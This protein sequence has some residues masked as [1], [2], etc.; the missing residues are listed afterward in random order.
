MV[1][2]TNISDDD[3]EN[4]KPKS[5][6][7]EKSKSKS[8]ATKS[9]SNPKAQKTKTS[10]SDKPDTQIDDELET[11]ESAESAE[12]AEPTEPTESAESAESAEYIPTE[13]DYNKD[14]F[15]GDDDSDLLGQI[16]GVYQL[17]WNW[18]YF[19]L[20]ISKPVFDPNSSVVIIYPESIPGG[21]DLEFVYP[22][23]DYGNRL[24]TSKGVDMYSVGLS[25]CKL[26]YTIEKMISILV[27]RLKE[28][29]IE[30]SSVESQIM[31][32]GHQLA[33]RKAFESVINLS[34]DV[35]VT[36]FD[37]GDWGEKYLDSIKRLADKGYGYPSETPRDI[38]KIH[39]KPSLGAGRGG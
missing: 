31:F 27:D 17:W 16:S 21:D 12:S 22:I 7:K 20:S 8:G 18:A 9:R 13:E 6:K 39:S 26:Y 36:N 30:G 4:K 35:V 10:K 34:Y 14:L 33:Q 15:A 25:M 24:T 19:E 28:G 32:D 2:K 1:K 11:T 23:F 29:G 38:Y 5:E 37:P 3:A